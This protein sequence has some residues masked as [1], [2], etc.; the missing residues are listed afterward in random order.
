MFLGL[1]AT[2][3]LT[4]ILIESEQ[5]QKSEIISE[6]FAIVACGLLIALFAIPVL[7]I[8]QVIAAIFWGTVWV[9][10]LLNGEGLFNYEDEL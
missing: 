10:K 9:F 1:N 5:K 3:K 8:I 4:V 7:V 6:K 2:Q